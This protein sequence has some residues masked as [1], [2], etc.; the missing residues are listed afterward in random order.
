MQITIVAGARPNFIKIAP[1]IKAIENR[2]KSGADLSYRLVH[3]GQHYDKNLSDTFFE[4]LN[5]PHPHANLEVKSGSQAVQTAAIMVAF[6]QE[7]LQNPTDLV[8][9]VGDVNSTMACAI[10]TKKLN[11]K[12]THVEAGIRSGDWTMPEE[13]NRIVTDSITDHFFTTSASASE[14]LLKYGASPNKVH[15][16]GNVMIDTLTQNLPRIKQPDFWNEFGLENGNYIVLTLHRPSNV[17]EEKSLQN[18]LLG[19]DKLAGDKKVVF[20]VHPR[21]KAILGDAKLD[22]KNIV[23]AE[24]QGYLAFM[25]LIKNSFAVITDSGGISEETTVLGIP[26]FTMRENTERP[27]TQTIGTNTLVGISVENLK[28]HFTDFLQ[29][30][31]REHGI[32]ELWDGK[33]SERIVDILL[34]E[35]KKS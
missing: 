9:V 7:L 11:I 32:P 18:L 3:T 23:Y 12:V 26:C 20:P 1:I 27:E 14:N 30:G 34:S 10:V 21:T 28:K 16:V 29:N 35:W 13:I 31:L 5:I 8:L 24:P 19:I 22:F 33:A 17:D 2:Q 6:E 25:Y 4:E 15:F